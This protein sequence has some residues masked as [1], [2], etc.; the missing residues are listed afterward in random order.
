MTMMHFPFSKH[1]L[2]VALTGLCLQSTWALNINDVPIQHVTVYPNGAL[3]ERQIPVRAGEKLI[4]LEGLPA[5]FDITA[6]KVQ[7]QNVDVTAVTHLDSA[8]NKPS[9][10][11]SAQLLQQIK[12]LEQQISKLSAQIQAAELQ[13]KFLGNVTTGNAS[14]VR[15]QAYDAFLTIST[16]S[17][18]K[19]QLEQR[20]AELNQDLAQIGD[21]QFN[22]RSLQLHTLAPQSGQINIAYQVPYATWRPS[23]KAELNSRTQKMTLT[24]MA[25]IAQKTGEDWDNVQITLST[26][27]PKSVVQQVEP[28]TWLVDYYEANKDRASLLEMAPPPSPMAA[29]MSRANHEDGPAFPQFEPVQQTYSTQFTTT[30]RT[31]IPSSSQQISLPLDQQ[32]LNAQLTAW[33][34]PQQ[35]ADRAFLSVETDRVT[36]DWPSG[37]IKLYR[38]GDY[39]G[40]RQ[41]QN[42]TGDKM[43][44]NFGEDEQLQVIVKNQ[45]QKRDEAGSFSKNVQTTQSKHYQVKNHHQQAVD[46]IVFESLP[47][48][49][50]GALKVS[51]QFSQPPTQTTWEGTEGIYQWRQQLAPQQSFDLNIDYQFKYPSDGYTSGF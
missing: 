23:Y 32:N 7:S 13:N 51:S 22:Q 47:Q 31:S 6:L 28:S 30:T 20:L 49:Q 24:R 10:R 19:Q 25:M 15:Q 29:K 14:T 45:P 8:L 46:L 9:G 1:L 3:I 35:R 4:S 33:V 21:H 50:N 12:Q 27:T 17:Q 18:E 38:D 11:E 42:P 16:A 40:Q 41:W 43:H 26:N 36:G 39:I 37:L 34:I 5:N 44:F 2:A 48:S